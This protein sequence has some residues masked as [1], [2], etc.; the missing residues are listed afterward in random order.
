MCIFVWLLTRIVSNWEIG[1]MVFGRR[2]AKY[3]TIYCCRKGDPFQDPRVSSCLTLGSESSEETTQADEA[4]DF[5]GEGTPGRRAKREGN[6][7]EPLFH[8]ACI[9]SSGF[10]FWVSLTSHLAWSMVV[11]TQVLPGGTSV[12]HP[13]WI[14]EQRI[15]G[16]WKDTLWAGVSSPFLAPPNLSS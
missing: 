6:P 3:K 8:I 1:F 4:R 13:R 2:V 12:F 5:I 14:S 11:L 10:S 9:H 15:Q 16:G 7:G